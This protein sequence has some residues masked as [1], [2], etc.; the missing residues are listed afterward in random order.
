MDDPTAQRELRR[1]WANDVRRAL[2]ASTVI[3]R[4]EI[5]D[6]AASTLARL[7]A[8]MVAGRL[9]E[10]YRHAQAIAAVPG[11]RPATRCPGL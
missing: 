6:L 4:R 8:A 7:H 1:K 2:L 11:H 9:V 3:D 10:C 5:D